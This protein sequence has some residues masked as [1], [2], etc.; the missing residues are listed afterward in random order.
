M[1]AIY[2]DPDYTGYPLPAGSPPSY[3]RITRDQW[4]VICR[5]LFRE[6]VRQHAFTDPG[7][8]DPDDA[9]LATIS[10]RVRE[11]L[12]G[13]IT[14]PAWQNAP[15]GIRI[16]WVVIACYADWVASG[17]DQT[18][19][20][21]QYQCP[22]DTLND[23]S[24]QSGLSAYGAYLDAIQPFSDPFNEARYEAACDQAFSQAI[25]SYSLAGSGEQTPS[26]S[27]DPGAGSA[28]QIIGQ[29]EQKK[30]EA[31]GSRVARS[32]VLSL[33]GAAAF[34]GLSWGIGWK[35]AP[36]A[37]AAVAGAAAGALAGAS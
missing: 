35:P 19:N 30:Q 2:S 29:T 1:L 8:L 24:Y 16:P 23:A 12:R 28:Y 36:R 10:Y 26:L 7:K 21:P 5:V 22:T 11:M 13:M 33:V 31:T 4:Y 17:W 20:Y 27:Q 15:W 14:D 34:Y 6:F 32:A 9:E 3:W 18:I 37:F 25:S